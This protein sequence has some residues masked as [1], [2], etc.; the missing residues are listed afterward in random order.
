MEFVIESLEKKFEK[1]EVL[2]DITFSF[3]SGKIYGLL[4]RN[5]AGKTTLFNCINRDIKA[6]GGSFWPETVTRSLYGSALS[7]NFAGCPFTLT[8]P[9]SIRSSAFLREATPRSESN[10]CSRIR[11]I[12]IFLV[13]IS[14]RYKRNCRNRSRNKF[15]IR[16]P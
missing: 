8:F 10:F 7:P 4:G 3:E 15:R 16:S 12:C 2:K 9:C 11:A 5:G 13:S 1:K 6:D 14:F